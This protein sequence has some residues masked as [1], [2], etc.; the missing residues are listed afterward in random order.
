MAPGPRAN[1]SMGTF[2]SSLFGKAGEPRAPGRLAANEHRNMELENTPKASCLA[3][4][5]I[6]HVSGAC[7]R[8]LGMGNLLC[9]TAGLAHCLPRERVQWKA[10]MRNPWGLN[11]CLLWDG[12]FLVQTLPAYLVFS[13]EGR[14]IGQKCTE[15]AESNKCAPGPSYPLWAFSVTRHAAVS[16]PQE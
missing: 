3:N 1:R 6:L 16:L 12:F 7:L 11:E 13:W 10:L 15:D 2:L 14:R 5:D 4:G 9:L 8:S